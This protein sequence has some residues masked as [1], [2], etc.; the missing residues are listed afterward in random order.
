MW[1]VEQQFKYEENIF[2]FM[3]PASLVH[4]MTDKQSVMIKEQLLTISDGIGEI[5]DKL[6]DVG[7]ELAG[8]DT[9]DPKEIEGKL[10]NLSGVTGA[11]DKLITG[12]DNLADGAS[13]LQ[14]GLFTAAEG[15]Q[16]ASQ[17]LAQLSNLARENQ[18]LKMKLNMMSEN[19]SKSSAG[20]M[21]MSDNTAN[22]K[23]GASNT[24]KAL[25]NISSQLSR[26][27]SEM[28][29]GLIGGLNP[30]DLQEMAEGFVTIGEKL[31]D[32]SEALEVFHTKSSMMV[33]NIP[34]SQ[35]E[36]DTILYDEDS[37]LR[38]IFD[39]VIVDDN[40]SMMVIKLQ[41]NL[42]DSYKDLIYT[43]VN[44]ALENRRF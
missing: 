40:H 43:D 30:N 14:G 41:G 27:T 25:T 11:F 38:T 2:S 42:E 28:K 32:I 44:A 24:S 22:L 1:N 21:T 23:E 19:I 10:E 18:E 5:A 35:D 15:L 13:Q 8:K 36:V 9:K 16:S 39:D 20:L 3:S 37:N 7:N 31:G 6:T 12:Q 17:Q 4:Q 33:A 29:S 26:E 34:T